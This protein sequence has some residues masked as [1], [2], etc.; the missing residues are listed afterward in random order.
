[1]NSLEKEQGVKSG[2]TESRSSQRSCYSENKAGHGLTCTLV[3]M[4]ADCKTFR[5]QDRLTSWPYTPWER[6]LWRDDFQTWNS[7]NTAAN[8][9]NTGET[10][11]H[12]MNTKEWYRLSISCSKAEAKK[13]LS[14]PQ[15]KKLPGYSQSNKSREGL[16][17][18]LKDWL[19]DLGQLS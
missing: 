18:S 1:M 4:K 6:Q 15:Q 12:R 9:S 8:D 11:L 17:P 2:E 14:N 13:E 5:G 16:H 3:F 19:D 7:D 10:W